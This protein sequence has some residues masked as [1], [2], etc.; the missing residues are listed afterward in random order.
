M[1]LRYPTLGSSR[2][3]FGQSFKSLRH[4][5]E[6]G[7]K[8][9]VLRNGVY[10]QRGLVVPATGNATFRCEEF[11]QNGI[12]TMRLVLTPAWDMTD[13]SVG[14]FIFGTYTFPPYVAYWYIF[15]ATGAMSLVWAGFGMMPGIAYATW[16]LWWN[17]Q[18]PNELVI[19]TGGGTTYGWL[20]GNQF[21]S[22]VVSPLNEPTSYFRIAGGDDAGSYPA[23]GV[24]QDLSLF[25]RTWTAADALQDAEIWGCR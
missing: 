6:E 12:Y 16:S 1:K 25:R 8:G 2:Q 23:P 22:A 15:P 9:W 7:G 3:Y 5:N 14:R 20:N 11:A 17:D 18:A 4:L 10:A 19:T 21:Y 24:Y 13:W